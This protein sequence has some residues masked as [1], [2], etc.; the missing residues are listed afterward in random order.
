[1]HPLAAA[2]MHRPIASKED[3]VPV[4]DWMAVVHV[5]GILELRKSNQVRSA[6]TGVGRAE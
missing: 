5:P 6:S 3:R 2:R 1:M 4:F